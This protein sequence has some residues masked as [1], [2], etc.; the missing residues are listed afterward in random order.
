M[1]LYH[2]DHRK[3]MATI[4]ITFHCIS[5]W[6]TNEENIYVWNIWN[7][8]CS[9]H[10]HTHFPSQLEL[11]TM[12]VDMLHRLVVIK[13]VNEILSLTLLYDI[14]FDFLFYSFQT[15]LHQASCCCCCELFKTFIVKQNF[16]LVFFLVLFTL[17]STS[18]LASLTHKLKLEV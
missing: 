15:F 11:V 8:L 17:S 12:P 9:F 3:L 7:T 13:S 1:W 5:E 6:Q 4:E 16:F 18:Q 14:F 10:H 2:H